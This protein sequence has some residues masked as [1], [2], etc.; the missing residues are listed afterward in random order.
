MADHA[1][2]VAA[3]METLTTAL[4]GTR[5][6]LAP[7]RDGP[8]A[9]DASDAATGAALER[10]EGLIVGL[11]RAR[12]ALGEPAQAADQIAQRFE[13][14]VVALERT[15]GSRDAA[16]RAATVV[17]GAQAAGLAE[18]LRTLAGETRGT[19]DR[20]GKAAA[21]LASIAAD[22]VAFDHLMDAAKLHAAAKDAVNTPALLAPLDAVA[23]ALD[24]AAALLAEPPAPAGLPPG[25]LDWLAALYTMERERA[26][27]REALAVANGDE[28]PAAERGG[29][30]DQ[31]IAAKRRI[32]LADMVLALRDDGRTGYFA[33]LAGGTA[34]LALVLGAAAERGVISAGTAIGLLLAQAAL[35]GAA[36]LALYAGM[37]RRSEAAMRDVERMAFYDPLTEVLNRRGLTRML[38]GMLATQTTAPVAALHV[39]L[40]H[41]KAVNDTLGHEAG[42]TVLRVTTQRMRAVV[43][44]GGHV[45]RIGGDEFCVVLAGDSVART[46]EIAGGLVATAR[47]PIEVGTNKCQIGASIGIATADRETPAAGAERL[48]ADADLAT[49]I[50]KSEGRGRFAFFDMALREKVE[51]EGRIATGLGRALDEGRLALWLQPIVTT[52]ADRVVGAEALLRWHDTQLGAVDAETMLSV[53]EHH[54]LLDR[55]QDQVHALLAAALI[56]LRDA[57]AMPQRIAMNMDHAELRRVGVAD[58]IRFMLDRAD[59]PPER[60]AVE[61][62]ESA[63]GGRGA[64]LAGATLRQLRQM[65]VRIVV[66]RFGRDEVSLAGLAAIRASGVKLDRA[67]VG[68]LGAGGEGQTL[69]QGLVTLSRSLDVEICACGVETREQLAAIAEVGCDS[70]QGHAI[71]RA[72]PIYSFIE[73]MTFM[74]PQAEDHRAAG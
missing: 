19:L 72:Q 18:D 73:W 3:A 42:D 29:A 7:R 50:A 24:A 45:G 5:R 54:N 53:A 12:R 57:D 39:D 40:D 26:L 6:H 59:C 32:A 4:T 66:D 48:L 52:G 47:E 36:G 10:A 71:A 35:A 51:R 15:Q 60:L 58:R 65:G 20:I 23:E 13:H 74:A 14:V 25:A 34:T 69:L 37:Q 61:V 56:R 49:Y 68:Q 30:T 41:F 67:L 38:E 44:D 17:V 16:D 8:P 9:P 46:R 70:L 33:A 64:Q 22:G 63:C 62:T 21:E 43:G 28:A 27:H 11:H 55:V 31:D 1:A 2:R